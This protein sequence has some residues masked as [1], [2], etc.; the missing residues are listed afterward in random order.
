MSTLKSVIITLPSTKGLAKTNGNNSTGANPV[1]QLS[2]SVPKLNFT[3]SILMDKIKMEQ[4]TAKLQSVK[5]LE[6]GQMPHVDSLP[7][8]FKQEADADADSPMRGK[9]RRLD[10]LTWEEKLQ[11]KKLKNRVA[12]Q[13]SRDRKKAKLDELEET[14]RIL[15]EKNERL[16]KECATL[17]TCNESLVLETQRLKQ[18]N[19]LLEAKSKSL[20]K[21]QQN[22][23][24]KMCQT[25]VNCT[26][27]AL[28]SAVSPLDSA[29]GWQSTDGTSSDQ[30]S[31]HLNTTE[32]PDS[33]P[34]LED[35]F[36]EFQGDD[37]MERLEELAESLLREVTT[38]VETDTTQSNEQVTVKETN[39]EELNIGEKVVGKT[40]S[41]VEANAA[42]G[43]IIAVEQQLPQKM[44]LDILEEPIAI[45][46]IPT[47]TI[48]TS[49]PITITEN[50]EIKEEPI[51][52]AEMVY[53]TYD[54]ATN[55]ITIIYPEED[56]A[57]TQQLMLP[58]HQLS[59]SP[60]PSLSHSYVDSLSPASIH[61]EDTEISGVPSSKFESVQSDCGY[62][63]HGS[64]DNSVGDANNV[65]SDLW[66]ESF[67]ELFPSLA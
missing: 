48:N 29:A 53:G 66:H 57:T 24:C 32:D 28:G 51:H 42:D 8:V 45:P 9:K 50:M 31:K 65:F 22:E 47:M 13:T 11:R 23:I 64:P 26:V 44:D 55:C 1:E 59:P 10:H 30:Q 67:S 3:T 43:S 54:E 15:K 60:S 5:H 21:Q 16:M 20:E 14:V 40:P 38:Q 56:E 35:L 63:S 19:E 7:I 36:G 39:N 18:D 6:L 34:P 33:L 46:V 58:K 61:S 62:E 25:R 41:Y 52:D 12:A 17:R 4:P 27:P 49:G 37:Y 2:K